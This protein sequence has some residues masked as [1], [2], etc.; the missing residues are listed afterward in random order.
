MFRPA[1][2]VIWDDGLTECVMI[3][4][5]HLNHAQVA[6]NMCVEPIS[7]GYVEFQS[8]PQDPVSVW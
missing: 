7:A 5:A 4:S 3:F 2:Y 6:F 1:K 8:N